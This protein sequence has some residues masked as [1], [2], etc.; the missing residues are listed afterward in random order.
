[1]RSAQSRSFARARRSPSP[2]SAI[3]GHVTLRVPRARRR[4]GGIKRPRVLFRVV[5]HA[6]F[7]P[8]ATL[9]DWVVRPL[10]DGAPI[11]PDYGRYRRAPA[12]FD[13][14]VKAAIR[15]ARLGRPNLQPGL[16]IDSARANANRLRGRRAVQSARRD[17]G[18]AGRRKTSG[19]RRTMGG[20]RGRGRATG[21]WAEAVDDPTA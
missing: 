6:D 20:R 3:L 10:V 8:I 7:I 12:A 1:M 2:Y 13:V 18:V 4:R 17:Q 16:L 9:Q 5:Q 11:F 19:A 14:R 21:A 15:C